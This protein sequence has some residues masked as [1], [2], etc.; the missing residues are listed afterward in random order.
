MDNDIQALRSMIAEAKRIAFLGGAGLST[1]SGI[2]DF[3]SEDGIYR[4]IREFGHPPETLLSH[5]FFLKHTAAFYRYYR[6]Y[7]L[8]PN[9]LPN[10]AHTALAKLEWGDAYDAHM[11]ALA[12]EARAARNGAAVPPAAQPAR[13]EAGA[14]GAAGRGEAAR[15]PEPQGKLTAIV[16]Q[17]IDDLHQRAG[18]RNVLELHGS[19]YRNRCLHCDAFY[20][21]DALLKKLDASPDGVPRCGCGGVIKPDVVLYGEGLDQTVLSAA[22]AHISRADLLIIGGTSLMV[23]PAA[24]LIDY[25]RGR[26]VVVINLSDTGRETGADLTIRRSIDEVL[27]EAVD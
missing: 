20:S 13:A 4:A 11:A 14:A 24:A 7:L 5:S 22:I 21:L 9:A 1:A 6:K 27:S 16:T 19:V 10:R 26:H 8:Y 23:Y 18:S 17:N 25:F 12:A 3:R 2:P 15:G